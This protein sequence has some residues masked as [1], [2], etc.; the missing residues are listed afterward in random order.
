[1]IGHAIS[2]ALTDHLNAVASE[3]TLRSLEFEWDEFQM[4]MARDFPHRGGSPCEKMWK[5]PCFIPPFQGDSNLSTIHPISGLVHMFYV[6]GCQLADEF[7]A[8]LGVHMAQYITSAKREFTIAIAYAMW[9]RAFYDS[10]YPK[11]ETGLWNNELPRENWRWWDGYVPLL[12][13]SKAHSPTSVAAMLNCDLCKSSGHRPDKP[14]H[15][16]Q[17]IHHIQRAAENYGTVTVRSL[18]L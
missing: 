14:L 4:A 17:Y 8:M 1:M 15:Q 10:S 2:A 18:P 3:S 7:T 12:A 11:E 9:A 6:T 13:R 16:W 5:G